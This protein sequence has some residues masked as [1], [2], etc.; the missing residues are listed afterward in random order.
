MSL[1]PLDNLAR[2]GQFKAEPAAQSEIAGLLRSGRNRLKVAANA[3][4][5]RHA[6]A[7]CTAS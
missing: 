4:L 3:T 7:C 1:E 2:G 5:I 6:P